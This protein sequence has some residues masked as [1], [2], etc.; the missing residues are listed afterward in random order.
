VKAAY[1][2][3]K[4]PEIRHIHILY[5]MSEEVDRQLEVKTNLASIQEAGS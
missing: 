3:S 5:A 1:S 4:T 2:G